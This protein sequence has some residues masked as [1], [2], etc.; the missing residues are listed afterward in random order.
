V[1]FQ[2]GQ[3]VAMYP[4]QVLTVSL[5]NVT[6]QTTFYNDGTQTPETLDALLLSLVD[7]LQEW[8]QR[9]PI[10]NV[11]GQKYDTLFYKATPTNPAPP[12]DQPEGEPAQ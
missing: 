6:V 2:E 1:P 4:Y 7:H 11:E 10:I 5:T 8:D 12:P 3:P 9:D